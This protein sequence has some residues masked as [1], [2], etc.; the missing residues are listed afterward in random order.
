MNTWHSRLMDRCG[1]KLV[2]NGITILG[3][4]CAAK[5]VDSHGSAEVFRCTYFICNGGARF[6][7]R[8]GRLLR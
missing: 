3:C 1:P 4:Q 5:E 8:R 2:A 6:S 7:A